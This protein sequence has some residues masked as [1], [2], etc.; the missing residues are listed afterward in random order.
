MPNVTCK[1][2]STTVSDEFS[3][4]FNCG[5]L[6]VVNKTRS[7]IREGA[8]IG[9][10]VGF[11]FGIVGAVQFYFL[12]IIP[13]IRRLTFNP[14]FANLPPS[15]F[16]VFYFGYV[17]AIPVVALLG[18][19]LGVVFVRFRNH[20]PGHSTIRKSAIRRYFVFIIRGWF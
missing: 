7:E 13:E 19:V 16:Q 3:Y 4:C 8:V 12:V 17:M 15:A 5:N 18:C 10:F 20:I 11:L 9:G 1:K 2:C 14:R 6:L